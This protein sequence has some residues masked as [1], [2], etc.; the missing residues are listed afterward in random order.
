MLKNNC[1]IN[2]GEEDLQ[3]LSQ[4]R[5]KKEIEINR[6]KQ[7]L[8]SRVPKSRDLTGNQ[9]LETLETATDTVP[10]SEEQFSFWQARILKK[11]S[12]IPFP[13]SYET[14]EDLKLLKNKNGRIC[15]WFNGLKNLVFE[16]WCDRR[17]LHWFERFLEDQETKR[18]SKNQHSASL[19]T[20]R[21]CKISWQEGT[22]K[23]EPWTI[24]HLKL[25]CSLET[26]LRTAEGTQQVAQEKATKIE[27]TLE[28]CTGKTD[29]T[30]NQEAFIRRQQSTLERIN[31]PFPRPSKPIYQGQSSIIV[32]VSLGLDKLATVA[33]VDVLEQKV[34]TYRSIKQLLGDNYHLLQKMRLQ[35]QRDSKKRHQAQKQSGDNQ[36][37]TS[38]LGQHID[39]LLAKEIVKIA[40]TYRAWS[41]ALPQ[42]KN[43]REIIQSEVQARAERKIPGYKEG[44][45]QYAKQYRVSIHQWSYNRLS[46]N[47]TQ[48]ATKAG[49]EIELTRHIPSGSPHGRAEQLAIAAYQERLLSVAGNSEKN[50]A[51]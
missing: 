14:N 45:E 7:Q 15:V 20:L 18:L 24:H 31:T 28:N 44:Q 38:N 33:V 43:M 29:L 19:F 46:E 6:L 17:Q 32:G 12:I 40:Q 47:I 41:I 10:E 35:Q 48:Q 2:E 26:R 5:G 25:Y 21:S 39:R 50:L 27:K 23:G 37:G 4:R 42:L 36:F 51:S 34:L 3:Q 13:I 30:S 16:I 49:I 11:S 8:Q 1:Q 9:W 22:G